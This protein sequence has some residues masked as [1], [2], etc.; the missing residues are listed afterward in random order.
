MKFN[1][2]LSVIRNSKSIKIYPTFTLRQAFINPSNSRMTSTNGTDDQT[3]IAISPITIKL[4]SNELKSI[5]SSELNSLADIFKRN[6]FELRIAGGAVRDLLMD[7]TPHDLDF[8]TTATPDE[9][10]EMFTR[11]NVRMINAKGE[12]HGTITPRIN[13]KENFEV[14]TLRIDVTTDGRHAEVQFTRNW[15]LDANRRDLTINSL[16]MDL[17]GVVYD[18]FNGIQDIKNRKVTFVGNA[19]TRIKEDYLRILR[20]FRFYGR[21]AS[22]SNDHDAQTLQA[23]HA[24]TAGL[25]NISGERIWTELKKILEGNYAGEIVQVMIEQGIGKYLGLPEKLNLER[26]QLTWSRL[27]G[28][29]YHGVTLMSGLIDTLEEVWHLQSRLKMSAFER[30]SLLFLVEHRDEQELSPDP[31]RPYQKLVIN[32]LFKT[33][34]AKLWTVELLKLQGKHELAEKL[35]NWVIPRFPING[36]MVRERGSVSGKQLGM[37][38]QRLKYHWV[39][40]GFQLQASELLDMIPDVLDD[41]EANPPSRSPS[42][43]AHRKKNK[44]LNS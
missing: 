2:I 20:Y 5:Y 30:D 3:N 34:D 27:K 37:V 43:L 1:F 6:G 32:S 8:A 17:D 38:L 4:E 42:P 14:T 15:Q 19:D 13:D 23:I 24:N 11:E 26:F 39:E 16:F 41:L 29:T 31:I 35:D 25:A 9:M 7:L 28:K 22:A 10:K 40:S 12:K 36:N 18:Y 33:P 44:N 21:I